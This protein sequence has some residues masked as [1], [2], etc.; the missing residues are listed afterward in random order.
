M[1]R[2]G[3]EGRWFDV[4]VY[5]AAVVAVLFVARV[6]DNGAIALAAFIPFGFAVWRANSD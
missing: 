4:L 3:K 5:A 2:R 1:L 6:L